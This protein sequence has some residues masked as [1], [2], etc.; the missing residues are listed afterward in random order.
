M[1]KKVYIMGAGC[2]KEDG[3]PLIN[4]FFDIAFK[5][6]LYRTDLSPEAKKSFEN[7]NLNFFRFTFF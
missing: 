2:S 3:A 7:V 1:E 6:V 5:E 4:E